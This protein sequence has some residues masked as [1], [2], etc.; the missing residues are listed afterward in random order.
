MSYWP[1]KTCR[2]YMGLGKQSHVDLAYTE[3]KSLA[4]DL[5]GKTL[6]DFGCGE[7]H[8]AALF[9]MEG[10]T[11][12][13]CVDEC[14]EMLSGAIDRVS[15]LPSSERGIFHF[16]CGDE[17]LLPLDSQFD[18]IVCSLMLMMQENRDRLTSAIEG[19]IRSLKPEG[20]LWV[21]LTHPCFHEER[22]STFHFELPKD[23]TYWDSGRAY[24]VVLNGSKNSP[25]QF[26]DYHW[27][28]EDYSRAIESGGGMIRRMREVPGQTNQAGLPER[29]PAYLLLEILRS[30]RE[31]SRDESRP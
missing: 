3:I 28:L 6:M 17:T 30:T 15:Q 13:L 12:F 9:A 26:F 25:L 29:N 24:G 16:V 1:T 5:R 22:H 27:T 10:A 19:L 14:L 18:G 20:R 23:F 8:L 7:G 2:S 4:G 21:L 31:V 11:S